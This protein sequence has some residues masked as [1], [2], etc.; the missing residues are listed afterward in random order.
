MK[1]REVSKETGITESVIH[2]WI[3]NQK[4]SSK[5]DADGIRQV[6]LDAVKE[7]RE[8][9]S[10]PRKKRGP[11]PGAPV[12]LKPVTPPAGA[13]TMTD[14]TLLKAWWDKEIQPLLDDQGVRGITWCKGGPLELEIITT[15]KL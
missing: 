10:P 1:V 7:Y 3:N 14:G 15:V 5:V 6:S 11:M 8:K 4:V 12:T 9:H 2:S 13:P